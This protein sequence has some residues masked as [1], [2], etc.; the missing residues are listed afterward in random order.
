MEKTWSFKPTPTSESDRNSIA[1]LIE[2]LKIST[3]M[4]L[5]LWQRNVH[6]FE[7][8]KHFFR[9]QLEDLH[10]PFLMMDMDLAVNRLIDAIENKEKIVIF[11]DYDVDGTTAVALFY[12]FLSQ[13]YTNI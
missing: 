11:G 9:P 10:D 3:N 13:Y 6:S 8:A 7:E 2:S 4:A 5:M 1:E 12:G